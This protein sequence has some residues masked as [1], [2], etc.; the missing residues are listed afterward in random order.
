MRELIAQV[1]VP[2]T[3]SIGRKVL[4]KGLEPLTQGVGGRCRAVGGGFSGGV[5][6]EFPDFFD[7]VVDGILGT[8][9]CA[10]NTAVFHKAQKEGNV[11]VVDVSVEGFFD[12]SVAV[13]GNRFAVDVVGEGA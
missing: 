5:A 4:E 10:A 9:L 6:S 11:D 1:H 12:G 2:F 8:D 13:D 7:G 3:H